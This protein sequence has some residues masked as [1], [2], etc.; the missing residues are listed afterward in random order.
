MNTVLHHQNLYRR[1]STL[2]SAPSLSTATTHQPPAASIEHEK[3]AATS[4]NERIEALQPR[5][6]ARANRIYSPCHDQ[7]DIFQE[8]VVALLEKA[9]REPGFADQT[10]A[11][12]LN[13]A[14]WVGGKRNAEKA[15][16]YNRYVL[17]EGAVQND[18][19][20][21]TST[22]EFIPAS[23]P[24]PEEAA[25]SDEDSRRFLEGIENL[26]AEQQKIV[27]MLYLD[28]NQ[29]EISRRLGVTRQAICERKKTLAKDLRHNLH[30]EPD[31]EPTAC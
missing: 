10:D 25:I 30:M 2:E 24:T 9:A 3:R 18:E 29:T 13:Y 11:Y 26:T 27:V 14:T 28:Y 7:E 8:M 12:L 16:T 20:D 5:L 21:E 1:A 22:L 4:I 19:G 17:S 6:K 31:D 15:F 23:T